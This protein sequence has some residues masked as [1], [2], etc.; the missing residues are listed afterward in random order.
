[1]YKR[2]YGATVGG[3]AIKKLKAQIRRNR[4][5]KVYRSPVKGPIKSYGGAPELKFV[6]T[7]LQSGTQLYDT[8]GLATPVNLL[9][10][11][12][13]NTT[14]DGRQVTIKSIQVKGIC[15]PVD[16]VTGNAMCR[17][18]VVWDNA[19][20]SVSTTSANL[21][22]ALLSSSNAAAFPLVDNQTRFTILWDSTKVLGRTDGSTAT[23]TYMA[24]PT[25]HGVEYYR[26]INQITQYSGTTAAIGSIQNGSLWF[27]TI[28]DQAAGAGGVFNGQVRVR[29]C[30]N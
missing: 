30:D 7:V 9:A 10:V 12:D 23:L 25:A 28:G 13:D 15:S 18:M 2:K 1:M 3:P 11:G 4:A 29:F 17:T 27:V 26:R 24:S 6:D 22:A 5:P 19:N 8:T 20:N 16:L 21:I 14:R